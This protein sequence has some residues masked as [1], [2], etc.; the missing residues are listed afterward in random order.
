MEGI[1]EDGRGMAVGEIEQ[2]E[3][4]ALL[5][6]RDAERGEEEVNE[7]RVAGALVVAGDLGRDSWVRGEWERWWRG[8]AADGLG[9]ER[10]RRDAVGLGF[11]G[12]E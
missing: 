1:G 11:H 10:G 7:A 6:G 8:E 4:D 2:L 5:V 12:G 9:W 3:W